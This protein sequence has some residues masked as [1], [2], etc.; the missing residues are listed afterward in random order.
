V[1]VV[2]LQALPVSAWLLEENH[3]CAALF[4]L[5]NSCTVSAAL[6]AR[7]A[8]LNQFKLNNTLLTL[9]CTGYDK[10]HIYLIRLRNTAGSGGMGLE[11]GA[12][13]GSIGHH[14]SSFLLRF[15]ANHLLLT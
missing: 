10:Q 12:P 11:P 9:F 4:D 6:T 2:R 13:A 5:V 7:R 15:A 3:P 1:Q 14:S 8:I